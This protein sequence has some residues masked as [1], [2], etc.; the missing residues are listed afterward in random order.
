MKLWKKAF[1]L[2]TLAVLC[3]AASGIFAGVGEAAFK[4]EYKM[5]VN[6]GENTAWG[7]SAAMFAEKVKEYTEGKVNIKIYWSA[8]LISGKQASELMFIRNGTI[9]FSLT[10]TSNFASVLTPF[11]IFNLPFFISNH[12]DKFKAYDALI[13]GETGKALA[14]LAREKGGTT[15]IYWTENGFRELHYGDKRKAIAEPEDMKGLKIRYVSSPLYQ[16][17]FQA[18][19]ANPMVINWN[20]ALQGFQQGLVDGGENTYSIIVN[21]KVYEFHKQ[22]TE[23]SYAVPGMFFCANN[24]IWDGFG[25]E[26]QAQV[27]KAA[28]EA[29]DWLRAV[30][31]LGLD[32][33]WGESYLKSV[34]MFPPDPAIAPADPYAFLEEKGVKINRLTP[35]Q[36][37]AFQK[38]VEP[39]YEKWVPRIGAEL[40]E[41][42]R[43]EMA[44]TN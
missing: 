44:A 35:E 18:L 10:G 24:K 25:P 6:V 16:D 32:D 21:Y 12:K 39:V 30:S 42:A 37:A 33:G 36:L 7:Q 1:A 17:T 28:V 26:V 27:S 40:V 9:D 19:S 13:F 2:A 8:Q 23:W 14:E 34:G 15:I 29:G 11:D 38:V 20:E 5:H 22:M 41:T 3:L 43:R 31:R 4:S